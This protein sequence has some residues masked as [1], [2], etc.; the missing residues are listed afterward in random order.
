MIDI[1]NQYQYRNSQFLPN[2]GPDSGGSSHC[3]RSALHLAQYSAIFMGKHWE[4]NSYD[5]VNFEK[6]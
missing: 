1:L 3:E 2:I 4:L 5:F 6:K